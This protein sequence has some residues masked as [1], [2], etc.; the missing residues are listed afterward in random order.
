MDT[1]QS[2]RSARSRLRQ[3]ALPRISSR[4]VR[5][6][7]GLVLANN[8]Q[9]TLP[10][11]AALE[12]VIE[13]AMKSIYSA[14]RR[15]LEMV[16]VL[17]RQGY[18]RLRIY[19]GMSPSGCYWRCEFLPSEMTFKVIQIRTMDPE[20]RLRDTR[21]D[22][23]QITLGG[24]TRFQIPPDEIAAKFVDRFDDLS[25][26]SKGKD[27]AYVSWYSRMLD[28]T[29]PNGIVYAYADYPVPEDY[30]SVHNKTDLRIPFPP[31]A[32]FAQ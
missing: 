15:L 10:D 26:A 13:P 4:Y 12:I 2:W 19:P 17:H 1:K 27:P 16:R 18:E 23:R 11:H 32:S 29:A 7:S 24:P 14:C 28:E 8:R 3:S 30:L 5:D 20:S 6:I 21:V 9:P 25:K 22:R 31:R